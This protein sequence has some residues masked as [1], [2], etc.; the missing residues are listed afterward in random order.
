MSSQLLYQSLLKE[1][2]KQMKLYSQLLHELR[3]NFYH[4]G[5]YLPLIVETKHR[6]EGL[7]VDRSLLNVGRN[8][9]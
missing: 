6:L 5:L 2:T 8:K 7:M 3:E 9:P 1:N 4:Q